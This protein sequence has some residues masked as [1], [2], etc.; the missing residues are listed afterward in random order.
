MVRFRF[1]LH[2]WATVLCAAAL[3]CLVPLQAARAEPIRGSGSTFAAPL[4]NAWAKIYRNAR[5]DGGDF[6]SPDW[7]VDFE[8]VGSTGGIV[9]VL[10]PF[11]DFAATDA[12]LA[13][14]ELARRALVQFPFVIGGVAVVHNLEGV[15]AGQLRLTADLLARIYLGQIRS[16]SDPELRALNPDLKL[17]DQ[18]IAV[19]HRADGSGTTFTLT[20]YLSAGSSEWASR[21]GVN[22][23]LSWPTGSG[24]RGNRGM[25]ER[26][27]ATPG[28]IG[29]VEYGQVR[30]AG[31]SYAAMANRSGDF[32]RPE[33]SGFERAAVSVDWKSAPHFSVD[34]TKVDAPGAYPITAVTYALL[35][36]GKY[37]RARLGRVLD[38]F[39]LGLEQGRDEAIALGY[40]PLPADLADLVRAYW[41]RELNFRS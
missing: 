32:V 37:T 40:I 26:V 39:R 17:P 22:T 31:L 23:E 21:L 2:K 41:V 3:W 16:W 20:Q 29:Y 5:T 19:V 25:L 13:A 30:R 24:A 34:L 7:T 9:R 18:P 10:D 6:T 8:A 36:R 1:S 14:E 4:I 11:I 33:R 15:A 35:P 12:P 38:F 27:R 28:A